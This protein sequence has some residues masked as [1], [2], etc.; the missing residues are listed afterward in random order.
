MIMIAC[1]D[2][3]VGPATGRPHDIALVQ[4]MLA[5]I[6]DLGGHSYWSGRIDGL[7][8]DPFA[9]AVNRFQEDFGLLD[10][11]SD[12]IRA[13]VAPASLTFQCLREAAPAYLAGIRAIPGTPILYIPPVGGTQVLPV[14]TARLRGLGN[15]DMMRFGRRLA[16]LAERVHDRHRLLLR[17]PPVDAT[18]ETR[19]AQVQFHGL[20]W[21]TENGRLTSAEVPGAHVPDALL[22]TL[23][24]E[25]RRIGALEPE[26]L[27][28][29]G[30]RE[31]WLRHDD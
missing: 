27:D 28:Y 9:D 4:L 3:P 26:W 7:G 24:D 17:F 29:A 20:K 22:T 25:A 19:R 13:M 31:L 6:S 12:D 16:A 30:R 15:G 1:L 11:P 21:V 10:E 8:A 5:N 18:G 14:L 2:A 23:A